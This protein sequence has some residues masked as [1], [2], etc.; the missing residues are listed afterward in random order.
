LQPEEDPTMNSQPVV[1]MTGSHDGEGAGDHDVP[2]Q[3]GRRPRAMAPYPFSTRQYA[4]LLVLRS[5]AQAGL[6]GAD[7]GRPE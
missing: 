1:T 2:F 3:F 4:R 7:D 5:Q 6:I